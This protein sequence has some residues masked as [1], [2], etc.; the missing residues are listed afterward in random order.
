MEREADGQRL[1]DM[2]GR[3]FGVILND[4]TI[5]RTKS[6]NTKDH[7]PP[8][9]QDTASAE[10]GEPKKGKAFGETIVKSKT[11]FIRNFIVCLIKG[12]LHINP[13]HPKYRKDMKVKC[14]FEDFDILKDHVLKK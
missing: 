8:T 7:S 4:G 1:F 3:L 14:F 5:L 11:I 10:A 9:S 13:I 2:Q 12:L 6:D